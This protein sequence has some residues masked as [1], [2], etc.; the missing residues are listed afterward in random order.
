[1][2]G[3]SGAHAQAA[4][5]GNPGSGPP[6]SLPWAQIPRFDPSTTDLRVYEQKMKFLH[7]IW[8]EEHLQ[9]LAPRAALLV[10]GAAFQK[11]ARSQNKASNT[12]SKP[13]VASGVD[14]EL[15]KSMTSLR[16]HYTL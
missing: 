16:G 14:L 13:W 10:E 11:V 1:M 15:K 2:S 12:W 5:P 4:D 8:P 7:A 6:T 3:E 9:Y